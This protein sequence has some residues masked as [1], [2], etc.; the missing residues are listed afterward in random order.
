MTVESGP[1]RST[2]ASQLLP[3]PFFCG[4]IFPRPTIQYLSPLFSPRKLRSRIRV[5][6]DRHPSARWRYSRQFISNDRTRTTFLVSRRIPSGFNSLAL[7]SRSLQR[8]RHQRGDL[9]IGASTDIGGRC[10][11]RR[12]SGHRR[13]ER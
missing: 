13:A 3:F 5:P 1:G 4:L 9:R 12:K 7:L 8:D 10:E 11:A 2:G 6:P